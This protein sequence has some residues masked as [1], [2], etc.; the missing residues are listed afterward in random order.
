MDRKQLDMLDPLAKNDI[1]DYE[2]QVVEDAQNAGAS[3]DKIEALRNNTES[4]GGITGQTIDTE[5]LKDIGN[6]GGESDL[7][8]GIANLDATTRAPVEQNEYNR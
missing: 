6:P 4:P 7:T 1:S 3:S 2:K 8:G 5:A